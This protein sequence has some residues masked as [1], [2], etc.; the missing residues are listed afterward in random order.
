MLLCINFMLS[1]SC[2]RSIYLS[3]DAVL[4]KMLL[5]MFLIKFYSTHSYMVPNF[6]I[7]LNSTIPMPK[8]LNIEARQRSDNWDIFKQSWS[9][10]EIAS[11]LTGKSEQQRLA[12]LLAIIGPEAMRV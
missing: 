1:V 2:I 10:Y 5:V 4:N 8:C 3:T 6:N 12:T 11:E 7:K 9:N